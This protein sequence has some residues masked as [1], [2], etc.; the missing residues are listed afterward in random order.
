MRYSTPELV[1]VGTAAGLVQGIPG[2]PLDNDVS[3]KSRPAEGL[4]LG[5]DD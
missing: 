5:L 3:V 2:G 1:I 4:A